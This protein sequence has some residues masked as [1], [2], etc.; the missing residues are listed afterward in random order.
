MSFDE[1]LQKNVYNFLKCITK[2]N[3]LV[4]IVNHVHNFTSSKIWKNYDRI[5]TVNCVNMFFK[6]RIYAYLL[7]CA[8]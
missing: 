5:R 7:Y 2:R 6:F 4:Y 1:I 8:F 3:N